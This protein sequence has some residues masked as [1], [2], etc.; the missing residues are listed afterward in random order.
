[1]AI[2]P[3]QVVGAAV[4]YV[5]A[6]AIVGSVAYL[7]LRQEKGREYARKGVRSLI[8]IFLVIPALLI[9]LDWWDSVTESL[10]DF[11]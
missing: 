11:F 5:A 7:N 4:L 2:S 1:L 10:H 8:I 6:L 9:L 3:S